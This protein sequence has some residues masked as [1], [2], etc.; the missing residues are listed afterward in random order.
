MSWNDALVQYATKQEP[1]KDIPEDVYLTHD[2][3]LSVLFSFQTT[4]P[5]DEG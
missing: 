5:L 2:D 3:H 4:E 1:L